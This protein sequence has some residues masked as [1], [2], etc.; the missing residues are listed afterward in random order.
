MF[1]KIDFTTYLGKNEKVIDLDKIIEIKKIYLMDMKSRKI[2]SEKK[3]P[4]RR[5]CNQFTRLISHS[6]NC[7]L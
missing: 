6:Q 2:A 7:Y 5:T 3:M 4:I 1:R